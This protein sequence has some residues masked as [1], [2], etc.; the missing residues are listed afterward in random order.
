MESVHIL[1]QFSG[2]DP[3]SYIRKNPKNKISRLTGPEKKKRKKERKKT[4]NWIWGSPGIGI[5]HGQFQFKSTIGMVIM[6][7]KN[8][9]FFSNTF[10]GFSSFH[11][12][13]LKN[14]VASTHSIATFALSTYSCTVC[15]TNAE[16][17]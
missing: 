13:L 16:V 4:K 11:I 15:T 3:D 7:L 12:F 6:N 17:N 8:H 10:K 9:F 2:L 14:M 1:H 5:S